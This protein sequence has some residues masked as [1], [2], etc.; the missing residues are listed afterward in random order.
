M[1]RVLVSVLVFTYNQEKYIGTAI[2]SILM[3]KV[4]FDYEILIRDDASTDNTPYIIDDYQKRYP[5]IIKVVHEPINVGIN[6]GMRKGVYHLYS[7]SKGKYL[8]FLDGDDYWSY[9]VKLQT[10]VNYLEENRRAVATAHNVSCVDENG[11]LLPEELIDFSYKKKH[12][13]GKD[14]AINCEEFGHTSS[15][16]MRQIRNI[17][18]PKQRKMFFQSTLNGDYKLGITLGMLGYIYYFED[19]WSCRRK[20]FE[21]TSWTAMTYNKNLTKFICRNYFKT[22][23]YIWLAFG[24]KINISKH[25]KY[26]LKKNLAIALKDPKRQNI[27]NVNVFFV[28]YVRALMRHLQ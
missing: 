1:S 25:L 6:E 23:Q 16:V 26:L 19:T 9:D 8:A 11:R 13:Y 17:M 4:N 5:D 14:S 15:L 28:S 2:D 12:I 21:G 18:S 7:M 20:V 27:E 24:E 3:Q 22:Q 10:Q